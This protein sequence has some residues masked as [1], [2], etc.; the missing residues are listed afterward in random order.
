MVDRALLFGAADI[1]VIRMLDNGIVSYGIHEY[2]PEY[3]AYAYINLRDK[4][5]I[6]ISTTEGSFGNRFDVFTLKFEMVDN[7]PVRTHKILGL[8]GSNQILVLVREEWH[9]QFA[10][11]E[12]KLVGVNPITQ[13]VGWPGSAPKDA[14]AKGLVAGGVLICGDHSNL[15]ILSDVFPG[16]VQVI[17]DDSIIKKWS[18]LHETLRLDEYLVRFHRDE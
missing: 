6:Y 4:R 13:S 17:V 18:E 5:F 15:L 14:F 2:S 16:T 8:S 10:G 1:D 3:P 9:K 12:S 7:C 11:D